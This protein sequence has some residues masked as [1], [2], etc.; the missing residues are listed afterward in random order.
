M[1]RAGRHV[2]RDREIR[3]RRAATR[4]RVDADGRVRLRRRAHPVARGKIVVRR[5]GRHAP[6]GGM[7]ANPGRDAVGGESVHR[8]VVVVSHGQARQHQGARAA[9]GLDVRGH[10][11]REARIATEEA[12]AGSH[13]GEVRDD[14]RVE[15]ARRTGAAHGAVDRRLQGT[16]ISLAASSSCVALS[17]TAFIAHPTRVPRRA[18]IDRL[19]LETHPRRRLSPAPY[20]DTG[21]NNSPPSIPPRSHR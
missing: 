18:T 21:D 12:T 15:R 2:P 3:R 8:N 9:E 13:R 7:E 11:H 20:A 19:T 10:G 1:T 17:S 16:P 5:R 4:A 6:P 14:R